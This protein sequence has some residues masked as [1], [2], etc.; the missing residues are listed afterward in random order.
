MLASIRN[1][2]K[3]ILNTKK[4][5]GQIQ[6]TPEQK[7]DSHMKYLIVGLGNI[8]DEYKDTRHNIGFMIIEQL[9][10]KHNVTA[11]Q[12][13]LAYVSQIKY[14]SRQ[15]ILAMPT[16]YMNLSGKAVRYHMD[17]N[18]IPLERLLILTDDLSLPFGRLRMRRKGSDGGHNGLKDIQQTLG[19]QSYP[20][21]RFGIGSDYSKGQQI[22]FVLGTF[23]P[24]ESDKLPELIE[25]SCKGILSFVTIGLD[26]TM[27]TFNR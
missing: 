2:L 9:M 21:L 14:R 8:G 11:K 3:R 27:N 6:P 22:D 15:L 20:R 16:T 24:E 12:E 1:Y 25:E 26:R 5:P 7:T 23:T 18:N 4:N 10:E 19:T 17:K 13:R